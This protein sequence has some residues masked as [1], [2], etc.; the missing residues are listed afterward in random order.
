MK[1]V[2]LFTLP[3]IALILTAMPLVPVFRKMVTGKQAKHRLVANLCSFFGVCLLAVLL[4]LTFC[5]VLITIV[6]DLIYGA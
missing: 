6:P 1:T 3:L 2:L 4:L 5:P